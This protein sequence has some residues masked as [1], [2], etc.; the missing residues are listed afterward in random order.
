MGPSM[1]PIGISQ[2]PAGR[3]L[4]WLLEGIRAS[5]AEVPPQACLRFGPALPASQGEDEIRR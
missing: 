3:Q 4:G 1:P 5:G 2:N